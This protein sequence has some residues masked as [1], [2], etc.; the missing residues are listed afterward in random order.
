MSAERQMRR[1]AMIRDMKLNG[2]RITCRKCGE[3]MCTKI[4]YGWV[5]PAC[6]WESAKQ[7]AIHADKLKRGAQDVYDASGSVK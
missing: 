6:G 1:A 4:G 3:K 2:M 5:C 7:I